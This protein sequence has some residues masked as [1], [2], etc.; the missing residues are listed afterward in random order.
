MSCLK[1][2]GATRTA[3]MLPTHSR[4]FSRRSGLE[5]RKNRLCACAGGGVPGTV[6]GHGLVLSSRGGP[7]RN[8]VGA[9]SQTHAGLLPAVAERGHGGGDGGQLR[10]SGRGAE[11][12]PPGHGLCGVDGHRRGGHGGHRH[13]VPG[14]VAGAGAHPVHRP[15]RG[16]GGGA[17]V[18]LRFQSGLK[19]PPRGLRLLAPDSPS[20]DS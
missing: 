4:H 12:H 9:G 5:N 10:L 16:G 15:D 18:C 14:G 20:P 13:G 17:E 7:A 19:N 2:L 1:G 8:R 6:G 3:T 11:A